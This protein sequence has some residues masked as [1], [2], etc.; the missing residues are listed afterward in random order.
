MLHKKI[1][2]KCCGKATPAKQSSLRGWKAFAFGP[3][4]AKLARAT[5]RSVTPLL[6]QMCCGGRD[7][8]TF[9]EGDGRGCGI[10]CSYITHARPD[11]LDRDGLLQLV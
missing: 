6:G 1:R 3:R 11:E 5:S 8:D 2:A 9:I 7:A 4:S 10:A